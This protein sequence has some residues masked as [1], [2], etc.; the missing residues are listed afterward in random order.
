MKQSTTLLSAL[1][2]LS[3]PGTVQA[4]CDSYMNSTHELRLPATI[5]VPDSLPVGAE[6]TR[7]AFSGVV[8]GRFMNC[9]TSTLVS[10]Y[11]R[12]NG[13]QTPTPPYAW[14]TEAP[15]VGILITITDARPS[16]SLYAF[17]SGETVLPVGRHPIFTNAEA[18]FI[19]I[20]PV[21]DG[22]V[23]AGTIWSHSMRN[24]GPPAGIFR[25]NIN[26]A[27]RFVRPAATCNLATGDV[28]RTLTLP[29]I[30][31]SALR[32]SVYAGEHHF[33]LTANCSDASNVTFQFTGAPAPGN[34]LL[35][36]NT[37]TA[38]GIALWLYSR[39]NGIGQTITPGG[40][41]NT[42][43]LVVSG[44]RAVLPLGAAYHRNGTVSQGTL[45]STATVNITYN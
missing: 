13:M 1:L 9:A 39:I 20:G 16:T 5:T 37:G 27:I 2:V 6:I 28:N 10:I 7:T 21:T 19:K 12:Y 35:F 17:T 33:E 18:R 11:G 4:A 40:N 29:P 15:G 34:D 22:V 3:L 26:N 31:A 44:N 8:P 36:A 24:I 42:R 30:Q 23:P 43:T 25:L 14:R 41:G 45:A 38:G 32:D